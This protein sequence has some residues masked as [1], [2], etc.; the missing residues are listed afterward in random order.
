MPRAEQR[1]E[2]VPE[3]KQETEACAERSQS[4]EIVKVQE[5]AKLFQLIEQLEI[6][7]FCNE[8]R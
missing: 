5:Q 3:P 8:E 6:P 7:E 4:D 2:I 1:L